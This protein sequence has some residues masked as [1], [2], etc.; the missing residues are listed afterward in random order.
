MKIEELR[1]LEKAATPGPWE[2]R[3]DGDRHYLGVGP[4][5]IVE[6]VFGTGIGSDP[7]YAAEREATERETNARLISAAR[8]AL[9]KLLAVASAA[10]ELIESTTY[11]SD[12][13]VNV[14]AHARLSA[15]LDALE[16]E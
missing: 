2:Y 12:L 11:Q 1:R 6:E 7:G 5:C 3:Y 15:A 4:Y 14:R 9:P 16:A 8:N 13:T 10:N